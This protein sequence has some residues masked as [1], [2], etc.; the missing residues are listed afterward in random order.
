MHC[1]VH[2]C[3]EAL[4][5][6]M[7]SV[8][9]FLGKEVVEPADRK[10]MN[11]NSPVLAEKQPAKSTEVTLPLATVSP[12]SSAA[13]QYQ[14]PPS[15]LRLKLRTL[16]VATVVLPLA[17]FVVCIVSAFL[18]KFKVSGG[19]LARSESSSYRTTSARPDAHA[20]FMPSRRLGRHLYLSPNHSVC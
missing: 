4:Q 18:F 2:K 16:A 15:V 3:K 20:T 17:G 19:L 12:T 1:V 11:A 7:I 13:G 5:S 6:S 10:E 14:Q 8:M 9:L